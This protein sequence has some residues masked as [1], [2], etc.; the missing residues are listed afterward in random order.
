L[1]QQSTSPIESQK[2]NSDSTHT[3]PFATSGETITHTS[4][5]STDQGAII[6]LQAKT[7]AQ[8]LKSIRSLE[9]Q[10]N[11]HEE[12]I[13]SYIENPDS[14]D[15]KGF[16][17]NANEV[18]RNKIIESRIRNLQNEIKKFQNEINKLQGQLN[19]MKYHI[20]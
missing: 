8:I 11:L 5:L 15:N 17:A 2:N 10:I 6:I 14:H 4:P 18:L 12:K 9:K 16:L 1:R 13:Q 3:Q 19:K 20:E 7:E